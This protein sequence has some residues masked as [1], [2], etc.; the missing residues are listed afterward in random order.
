[1]AMKNKRVILLIMISL[2]AAHFLLFGCGTKTKSTKENETKE[3]AIEQYKA[4]DSTNKAETFLSSTQEQKQKELEKEFKEINNSDEL[5]TTVTET[6][7]IDAVDT[8]YFKLPNGKYL[9]A[10]NGKVVHTKTTTT[11]RKKNNQFIK[12]NEKIAERTQSKI[13]SSNQIIISK[14]AGIES[15]KEY[16]K[17]QKQT[18][19][20]K[21]KTGWQPGFWFWFWMVLLVILIILF[22]YFYRKYGSPIGWFSLLKNKIL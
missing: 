20:E 21:E 9:K 6:I 1:M 5:E 2:L 19:T 3:T 4:I 11:G 13:D 7:E 8:I 15:A 12:Q 14:R 17:S 16:I 10:S 18:E 22:I